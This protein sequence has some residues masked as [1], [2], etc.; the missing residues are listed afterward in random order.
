MPGCAL[1]DFPPLKF[2]TKISTGFVEIFDSFRDGILTTEAAK[3]PF[4]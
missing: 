3:C 1:S 4:Q 2:T